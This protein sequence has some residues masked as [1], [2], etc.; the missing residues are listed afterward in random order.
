MQSNCAGRICESGV[1]HHL[2]SGTFRM[3]LP[4]AVSAFCNWSKKECP[5]LEMKIFSC[6][7]KHQGKARPVRCKLLVFSNL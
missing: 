3:D 6:L 4:F 5:C 2:V 7:P 1:L